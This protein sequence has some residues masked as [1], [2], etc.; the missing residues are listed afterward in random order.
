MFA[1][2]GGGVHGAF[3]AE[4]IFDQ[5]RRSGVHL[6]GAATIIKLISLI[7]M[8]KTT[9]AHTGAIRRNRRDPL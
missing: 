3:F 8:R 9:T 1:S 4:G 6:T 5:L 7:L 2:L